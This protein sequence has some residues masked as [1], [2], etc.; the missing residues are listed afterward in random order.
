MNPVVRSIADEIL[1]GVD[2]GR[3]I[4]LL[5]DDIDEYEKMMCQTRKEI[6]YG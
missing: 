4:E 6:W 3:I 2:K 5:L 1:S